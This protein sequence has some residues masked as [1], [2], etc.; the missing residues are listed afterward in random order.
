[1]TLEMATIGTPNATDS[2]SRDRGV[3]VVREVGLGQH[4]DRPGAA[5]PGEGE[6]PLETA[7]VQVLVERGDDAARRRRS[8]RG[9][10]PRPPATPSCARTSCGAG[11][12]PGSCRPARRAAARSRPS[13]RRPGRSAGRRPVVEAP[14]DVA[15][16][17]AELGEDVV[18]AA[19]LHGDT[20]RRSG[21]RSAWGSNCS[22]RVS[23]QPSAVRSGTGGDLLSDYVMRDA[24]LRAR[25]ERPVSTV[26]SRR[27]ARGAARRKLSRSSLRPPSSGTGPVCLIVAE[28]IVPPRALSFWFATLRSR[29]APGRQSRPPAVTRAAPTTGFATGR[30]G[31]CARTRARPP[32]PRRGG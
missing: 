8:R 26:S 18:G 11:A 32:S 15:P 17:L 5:L 13:R 22:A 3:D 16:E 27:A 28:P 2:T 14:G 23:S 31:P 25:R 9:P 29:V 21:R 30:A 1:M 7:Q 12:P 10:A 6:V 19:M 20:A 4:E 24:R